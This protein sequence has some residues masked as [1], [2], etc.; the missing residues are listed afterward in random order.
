MIPKGIQ[1]LGN[2]CFLN[3]CIQILL[4]TYELDILENQNHIPTKKEYNFYNEWK[5]FKQH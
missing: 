1:N 3:A 2:T 4:Q 5:L